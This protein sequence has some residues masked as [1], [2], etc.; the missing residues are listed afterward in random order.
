M[1]DGPVDIM[2][3]SISPSRAGNIRPSVNERATTAPSVTM[4]GHFANVGDNPSKETFGRGV[5][6]IDE[7]KNFKYVLSCILQVLGSVVAAADV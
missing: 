3:A 2:A 1:L 7:D 6:V 4:N 5:Q